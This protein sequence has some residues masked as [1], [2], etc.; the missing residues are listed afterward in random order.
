[1]STPDQSPLGKAVTWPDRYDRSLLFPIERAHGRGELGLGPEPLPF[2]GFDRWTAFELSWLDAQGKPQA[3]MAEFRVPAA[4]PRLI[5]SKSLKLYLNSLAQHRMPSAAA[6][7][8][9]IAQDL[10][11]AAGAQVDVSM[12][13]STGALGV[14]ELEG[15]CVDGLDV[16]IDS[17]G[18]PDP[19]LLQAHR[20]EGPVE[21]SLISHLFRSNCPVTGQP[22][23][24]SVQIRYRGPRLE[25]TGLLKYLV[26][27]RTHSGFHEQCVERVFLDVAA[28]C[29]P[30]ALS[31]YARYT[32]RGGL[33]INPWR[34]TPGYAEPPP[35]RCARQ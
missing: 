1:M 15:E 10:S 5:E 27:F 18:P 19:G 2:I 12:L 25:R 22:D 3:G 20:D 34:A 26:S 23:W 30:E 33:D 31:V 35:T 4:S 32:R 6:L 24:A 8:E 29:V 7:G 14:R 13:P 28:R 16:T 9:S 11:G 17:Y 21:E